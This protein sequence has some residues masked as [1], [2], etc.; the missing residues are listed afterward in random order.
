[1]IQKNNFIYSKISK[2]D[3]YFLNI[4]S[5]MNGKVFDYPIHPYLRGLV[6]HSFIKLYNIQKEEIRKPI[7]QYKN[8]S[9]LFS[10]T[11]G[12]QLRPVGEGIISPVDGVLKLSNTI[13]SNSQVKI[14][15]KYYNL[16]QFL[17]NPKKFRPHQIA[18]IY[19]APNNYHRVHAPV[20]GKL[21][22]I[23]YIPGRLHP[24]SPPFDKLGPNFFLDNERLVFRIEDQ[25]SSTNIFLVMV[26]GFN[27]GKMTSKFLVDFETNGRERPP[28][29]KFKFENEYINKGEEIG[30]FR[31]GSTVTMV[32]EEGVWQHYIYPKWQVG[33]R[34]KMGQSFLTNK[35][36]VRL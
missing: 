13:H 11:L 17:G 1:M 7:S 8:I 18:S 16:S 19:L 12:N 33:S 15:R 35:T 21:I 31:L 23:S 10:R 29:Q 34:I 14:K 25:Q 6:N 22:D 2:L 27:V 9:E 28:I 30:V 20:N 4:L 5:R 3:L 32:F 26:G 24:L 36:E